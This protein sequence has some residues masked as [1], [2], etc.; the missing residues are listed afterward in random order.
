MKYLIAFA[1][2]LSIGAALASTDSHLIVISIDGLRPEVYLNPEHE[3]LQVPNLIALRDRG[4]AAERMIG[5]FPTVTYPSHVTLVTGTN[6]STHKVGTN[7]IR[8]TTN[9]H[10]NATDIQS[11]T[12][13]QAYRKAGLSSAIV[14]WPSSYG[15]EVNWL[16]P[17]N[18]T[19]NLDDTI[20]A[21]KKGGSPELFV[22]LEQQAGHFHPAS[23]DKA[24]GAKQLDEMTAAYAAAIIRKHHPNLMLMHFLDSDHQQH[25]YGPESTQTG[26]AFEQIDKHIG[27]IL[28]AIKDAGIKDT[29]N[30]V[31]V[32][33]HGFVAI[34]AGINMDQLLVDIGYA[35][36]ENQKVVTSIVDLMI[37][38]GSAAFYAKP[39]ASAKD[40]VN[41]NI[42]LAEEIAHKYQGQLTYLS[43]A[44]TKRLGG[45]P[46]ATATVVASAGYTLLEVAEPRILFPM[47]GLGGHGNRPDMPEMATGFIA[48]GPAFRKSFRIPL[49]HMLDVAP[50]LAAI[51][52][53]PLP[54]AEGTVVKDILRAH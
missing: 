13:W 8:G 49:M 4:V 51:N 19:A 10:L 24:D 25:A 37:S 20:G 29:T 1:L 32:G 54:Q 50:T 15:A 18:L 40:L 9:W 46:D 14:T 16:V 6:P 42:K 27:T 35:K 41:F 44:E 17:E 11:E 38:G 12:L 31:V 33:D 3:K 53:V 21:I 36:M 43:S 47:P 5:I 28:K 30:I 34:N 7:F 39:N 52:N 23:F 22:E 2:Y 45:Y 48:A 26:Q